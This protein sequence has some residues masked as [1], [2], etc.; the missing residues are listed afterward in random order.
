MMAVE[1]KLVGLVVERRKLDNPWVDH[2]WA[3]VLVFPEAPV[4]PP[5][6]TIRSSERA[7]QFYAGPAELTLHSTDTASYR[8][9][10]TMAQPLLWVALSVDGREPPVDIV[11][12]TAD[13]AEGEAL[14]ETGTYVVETLP[15]PPEIAAWVTRFTAEH[16]VERLFY[17]RK[18]DKAQSARAR[19][20]AEDE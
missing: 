11:C 15:M 12:V 8:D 4:T 10:L 19:P 1:R 16:H 17:K 7:T 14:T 9:N 2:A 20:A 6:T 18:R 3:P 13:P 5:W